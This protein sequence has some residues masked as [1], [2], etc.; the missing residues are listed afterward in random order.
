M[1]PNRRLV[2]SRDGERFFVQADGRARVEVF[3]SSETEFYLRSGQATVTFGR[4]EEGGPV[5]HLLL[6]RTVGDAQ[7]V[8]RVR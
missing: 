2:F 3:A 5:T 8:D 7:R 6:H 4:D 1:S